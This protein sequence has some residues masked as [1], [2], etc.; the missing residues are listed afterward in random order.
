MKYKRSFFIQFIVIMLIIPWSIS[1]NSDHVNEI[2]TEST[3]KPWAYWWWMGNSVTKKGLDQ[4]LKAYS[5]AGFGGLHIVPIYGEKGDEK[6]YINYLSPQW[7]EMLVYTVNRAKELG[8]GIDMTTGTGWPFGG[9]NISHENSAKAM[10][11]IE[12]D[13]T[14]KLTN[15]EITK[16]IANSTLVSISA[17][18]DNGNYVNLT[19]AIQG[20]GEIKN[21]STY[22]K[23]FALIMKPT[24]MKVERSAPGGDGLV[25]DYF[26]KDAFDHYFKKFKTAF[27]KTKF[28][29]GTVRAF[30]HDS[31]EV[32]HANFTPNFLKKFKELRGYDLTNYFYILADSVQTEARERVLTDYRETISDLL[33]IEFT[34]EWVHKSNE[35]GMIARN[36]AHGSPGNILDLYGMADIAETESFG[37]SNFTIP[38]LRK[39][40]DYSEKTFGRPNPLTM[41]FASSAAHLKNKKLVSA[42]TA[43]WLGDHFK[44]ALSQIKPQIDEL[45]TAGINHIFYHGITYNPPDKPFPGRLFYASTNFGIQ[46]HFWNELPALNKYIERCQIILQNTKPQN[47]VLVYFPIYDL[48]AKKSP[49]KLVL[50][51][52]VHHSKEW[53][54]ETNFGKEIEQLWQEGYTFDY[55]SDKILEEAIV[56]NNYIQF[57]GAK[58]KAIVI[59]ESEYI[60]EKTMEIFL[61][62]AEQGMDII[63]LEKLPEKVT[64]F[65]NYKLRQKRYTSLKKKIKSKVKISSNI[66]SELIQLGIV[67]EELTSSG[68]SFI[69]KKGENGI[70][71]FVSNLSD[72]FYAGTINLSTQATQ[73]MIFDPLTGEEGIASSKNVGGETKVLLHL[74]PGQ[75]RFLFCLEKK[76]ANTNKWTYYN[77]LNDTITIDNEWNLTPISGAPKLPKP[78]KTKDFNSWSNLDSD[79]QVFSGKVVYETQF[80]MGDKYFGIPFEIDLGDVRETAK[81]TINGQEIGLLW[82]LPYTAIIPSNLLKKNNKIEI[83]VT[84][85]SFNRVID[86]DK[87]GVEWKNFNEINFVN[88]KYEP[89]DASNKEPMKSGLLNKVKLIPLKKL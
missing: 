26:S 16:R 62:L 56:E 58:Y 85:L 40:I 86:L 83:E 71:Y 38:N 9:P 24:N 61:R 48:W 47:D 84:N 3:A 5:D 73:V 89:Y 22:K 30:Y 20:N 81:V 17:L 33:S 82:C 78:I 67:P 15:R 11:L 36:Q 12:L 70:V 68:L 42:E 39:D 72:Q 79:Y 65:N 10:S 88:I 2:I 74:K 32:K 59:P 51:L 18:N 28:T 14:K 7:M 21:L 13:L 87:K 49:R 37:S 31:Y 52:D 8:M 76:G 75:S 25:I 27:N 4:N 77:S 45:F 50:P 1:C 60:P 41:K 66:S 34:K 64:G 57:E 46:S 80:E 53:L 35:L 69:R 29:S 23:A 6:Q 44:V 19:S 43:T 55:V 63:F 54:A